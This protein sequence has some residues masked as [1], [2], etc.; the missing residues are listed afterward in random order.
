MRKHYW[1]CFTLFYEQIQN[2]LQSTYSLKWL[3]WKKHLWKKHKENPSH[4]KALTVRPLLFWAIT[5][6]KSPTYPE[7]YLTTL[8]SDT[9]LCLHTWKAFEK[10]NLWGAEGWGG[11]GARCR[12][13]GRSYIRWFMSSPDHLVILLMQAAVPLAGP[14]CCWARGPGEQWRSTWLACVP[15]GI[16]FPI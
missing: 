10:L 16:L 5:G 1:S 6:K 13:P 9:S 11:G 3:Q 14:L 7:R 2:R 4:R 12:A 15:N 8:L